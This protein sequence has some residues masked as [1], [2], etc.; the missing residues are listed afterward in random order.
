MS[1][2]N[3]LS[4]NIYCIEFYKT[5]LYNQTKNDNQYNFAVCNNCGGKSQLK[6]KV[7]WYQP[8]RRHPKQNCRR[9]HQSDAIPKRHTKGNCLRW[10]TRVYRKW[11]RNLL[12][13]MGHWLNTPT[14]P[15]VSTKQWTYWKNRPNRK[16]CFKESHQKEG[17]PTPS[18]FSSWSHPNQPQ[19]DVHQHQLCSIAE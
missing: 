18:P 10:R 3:Y 6:E 14:Q 8:D 2:T 16:T 9:T 17:R 1:Q 13:R 15:G 5:Q 19:Q 12:K 4:K 11:I 7:L